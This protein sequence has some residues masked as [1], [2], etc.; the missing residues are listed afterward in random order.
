MCAYRFQVYHRTVGHDCVVSFDVYLTLVVACV[1]ETVHGAALG[2]SADGHTGCGLVTS[3]TV[4]CT[5]P[6]YN[7]LWLLQRT[8]K[9][10]IYK[11]ATLA[12]SKCANSSNP[13]LVYL[14]L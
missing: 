12:M 6:T 10:L 9:T 2:T 8:R 3:H 13:I 1:R 5:R 11:A 7:V 4:D 14:K